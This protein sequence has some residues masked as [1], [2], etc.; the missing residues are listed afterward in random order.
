[1]DCKVSENVCLDYDIARC[2][3][4]FEFSKVVVS[5]LCVICLHFTNDK[6]IFKNCFRALFV[7]L[8]KCQVVNKNYLVIC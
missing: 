8:L 3:M 6:H 5:V 1:M 4:A 2:E 7:I